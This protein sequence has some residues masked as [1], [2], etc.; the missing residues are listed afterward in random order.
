MTTRRPIINTLPKT[1]R[2][3]AQNFTS[4]AA[5][6]MAAAAPPPGAAAARFSP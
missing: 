2:R 4:K 3:V 1:L 5:A 6:A